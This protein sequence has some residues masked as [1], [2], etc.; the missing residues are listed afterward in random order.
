MEAHVVGMYVALVCVQICCFLMGNRIGCLVVKMLCLW[1]H[2]I[3]L[4]YATSGGCCSI[5]NMDVQVTCC[6]TV[7]PSTSEGEHLNVPSNI[8]R[9]RAQLE[10][11][12]AQLVRA[13][14]V[15]AQLLV[16]WSGWRWVVR[17]EVMIKASIDL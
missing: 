10:L 16:L 4:T 8:C 12:G 11:V 17:G 15:R 3:V 6:C 5:Y 14:L 9:D 13:Q 2:R 1:L 7:E